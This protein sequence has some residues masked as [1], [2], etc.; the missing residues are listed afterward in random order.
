[1]NA[2]ARNTQ[3]R[4]TQVHNAQARIK[5][6][7]CDVTVMRVFDAPR[8]LVFRMWIEPAHLVRWWSPRGYASPI[9]DIEARSGGA[10]VMRMHAPNGNVV[11]MTGTVREIVAPER[12]VLSA[13]VAAGDGTALFEGLVTATFAAEGG[14]TRLTVREQAV[15]LVPAAAPALANMETS[16]TESL[17]RLAGVVPSRG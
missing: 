10:I 5:P 1:M 14:K 12:L 17:A 13:V 4:N 9:C 8:D 16:W 15:A 6:A 3:A 2:Q 11:L 7:T